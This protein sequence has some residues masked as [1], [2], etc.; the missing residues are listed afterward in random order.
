MTTRRTFI[1]IIPV[2]SLALLAAQQAR[3]ADVDP[4]DAQATALGYVVD[5]TKADKAK[6]PK[7]AAGQ[8][9]ANC[10]FYQGKAGDASGAC[11]LFAGKNVAAKGWCSA[12]AK[13]A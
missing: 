1:Q 9:C 8:T 3:A 5:A 10:Q 4:K 12:Y 11:P 6:F 2:T 7:Y 13:K